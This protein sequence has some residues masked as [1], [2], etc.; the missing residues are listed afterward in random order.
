MALRGLDPAVISVA[1]ENSCSQ[2]LMIANICPSI[3]LYNTLAASLRLLQ[4]P[5]VSMP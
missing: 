1:I 2:Q 5:T 3:S 4:P